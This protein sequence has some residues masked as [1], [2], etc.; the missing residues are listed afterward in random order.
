MERE[1]GVEAKQM[2]AKQE[3][4][5][6]EILESEEL[7]DSESRRLKGIFKSRVSTSE[8][9][10]V[11]ISHVLGLLKFRRHFFEQQLE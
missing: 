9:A 2:T 5:L 8:D 11:L 7:S 3:D 10:S 1:Y 6:K 4:L